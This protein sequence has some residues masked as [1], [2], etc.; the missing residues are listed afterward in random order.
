LKETTQNRQMTASADQKQEL[1]GLQ[2]RVENQTRCGRRFKPEN[3]RISR[4]QTRT[5]WSAPQTENQTDKRPHR[6]TENK[7]SVC[8]AQMG[9]QTDKRPHQQTENKN[10]LVS[11]ADGK[12]D[13]MREKI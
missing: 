8:T 6:Q 7:N 11:T 1:L 3:E 5:P 2:R 4:R 9:N 12:P 13:E 10:S